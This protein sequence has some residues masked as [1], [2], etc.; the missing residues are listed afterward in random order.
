MGGF[1]KSGA[2]KG[3]QAISVAEPFTPLREKHA[4]AGHFAT[5]DNVSVAERSDVLW[6][7]TKPD[8]V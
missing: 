2:V 7:A 8:V 6:L 5:E 3:T 1:V 4:K